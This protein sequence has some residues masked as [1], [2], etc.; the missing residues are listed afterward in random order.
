[1]IAVVI[2]AI[3]LGAAVGGWR[4]LRRRE[5]FQGWAAM[6]AKSAII[7][8]KDE[9][10]WNQMVALAEVMMQGEGGGGLFGLGPTKESFKTK[11]A[12]YRAAAAKAALRARYHDAMRR[13][14]EQAVSRPWLPVEPD[15]L[16]PEWP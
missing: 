7:I 13:K 8:R 5:S 3:A 16:P 2:L 10:N 12:D 11:A 6:H 15:P 14:Y 9:H 4:V 1:M